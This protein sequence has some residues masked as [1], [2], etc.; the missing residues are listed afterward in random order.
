MR[1]KLVR[2]L[3]G[4]SSDQSNDDA[5]DDSILRDDVPRLFPPLVW[6]IQSSRWRWVESTRG[7]SRNCQE[8]WND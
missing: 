4:Q 8:S 5:H 2:E 7:D 6:S 3:S 1:P